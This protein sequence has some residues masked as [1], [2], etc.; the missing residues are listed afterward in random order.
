MPVSTFPTLQTGAITQY[1][2]RR[3]FNFS[4]QV[5]TFVDGK[6]QRF[7]NYSSR[8][9]RWV[10][11]L[12]QLTPGEVGTLQNFY[13]DQQGSSGSFRFVDPADATE[14]NDCSFEEDG[15]DFELLDETRGRLTITIRNN[16]A[17]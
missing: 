13:L 2:A 1:P 17:Q 10:I 12:Q 15:F 9:V 14:Y 11:Q 4:T 16:R 8:V 6:T 5:T 7:R 3:S